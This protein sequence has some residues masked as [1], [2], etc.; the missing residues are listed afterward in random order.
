MGKGRNGYTAAQFISAIENSGGIISTI[1]KR[2]GCTWNTAK[3]YIDDYATVQEAYNDECERVSD[4]A[5]S[6]LIQSMEGGDV[7]SAKWWLSKKRKRQFGESIDVKPAL[8][9]VERHAAPRLVPRI[10]G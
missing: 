4:I 3:R 5:E 9:D 8:A 6:V 10:L 1:A 7:A 2:V